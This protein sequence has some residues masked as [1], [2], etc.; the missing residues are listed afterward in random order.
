[1]WV[2]FYQGF[3]NRLRKTQF[4]TRELFQFFFW[5]FYYLVSVSYVLPLSQ[6]F[7]VWLPLW[8]KTWC[9]KFNI[10]RQLNKYSHF[11]DTSF[12]FIF[13]WQENIICSVIKCLIVVRSGLLRRRRQKFILVAYRCYWQI[14]N[15]DKIQKSQLISTQG[16]PCESNAKLFNF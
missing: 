14:A 5:K 1:M 12:N 8:E 4:D 3:F 10:F 6:K 16:L 15:K 7:K 9:G 11:K 13:I 2:Y